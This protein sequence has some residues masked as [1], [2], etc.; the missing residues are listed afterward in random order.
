MSHG[1]SL[2]NTGENETWWHSRDGVGAF[3]GQ[4]SRWVTT[5]VEWGWRAL[6]PAPWAARRLLPAP[7]VPGRC[8]SGL[9]HYQAPLRRPAA[10]LPGRPDRPAV[11]AGQQHHL[12]VAGG[13][14]RLPQVLQ[15][16]LPRALPR[17]RRLR[18]VPAGEERDAGHGLRGVCCR[19]HGPQSLSSALGRAVGRRPALQ[20]GPLR[21]RLPPRWCL[22]SFQG[23]EGAR[24]CGLFSV[25]DAWSFPGKVLPAPARPSPA[26]WHLNLR[27]G[28]VGFILPF[29]L[30]KWV[31]KQ[32]LVP[33]QVSLTNVF[34]VLL[35]NRKISF[36]NQPSK[37]L[38]IGI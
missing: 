3:W 12:R 19:G 8:D 37:S 38:T 7:G 18:A 33:S 6:M 23:R 26:P 20:V 14:V 29:F 35:E 31:R 13:Q 10:A 32:S 36:K 17:H 2:R 22:R 30:L 21:T 28:S 24:G 5:C 4:T 9:P 27:E 25:P 15:S 34:S 11:R 1:L 16:C